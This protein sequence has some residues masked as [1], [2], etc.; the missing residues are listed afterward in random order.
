MR[1]REILSIL[2]VLSFGTQRVHAERGASLMPDSWFE[3]IPGTMLSGIVATNKQ[4]LV[5][6]KPI[7]PHP[8]V[9]RKVG[10][11]RYEPVQLLGLKL[12]QGASS[13]EKYCWD[14][15]IS[16]GLDCSKL[17]PTTRPSSLGAPAT[18]DEDL[19]LNARKISKTQ[20]MRRAREYLEEAMQRTDST[21]G[22]FERDVIRATRDKTW[23]APGSVLR[24]SKVERSR[25][26]IFVIFGIDLSGDSPNRE[27]IRRAAKEL[28]HMGFAA[29]LVNTKP[30]VSY[31]ANARLIGAEFEEMVDKVDHVIF[32]AASKGVADLLTYMLHDGSRASAQSRAKVRGIV[33]LSGVVRGSNMAQWLTHSE[34]KRLD[35]VRAFIARRPTQPMEGIESLALDPWQGVPR[36]QLREDFPHLKWISV[37]MLPAGNDGL[38]PGNG[39]MLEL[40]Q[41]LIRHGQ[42]FSPSDGLVESAATILPPGTGIPQRIVRGYGPHALALGH[43]LNGDALAPQNLTEKGVDPAA[44]AEILS[45][46]MR[47]LGAE[48]L[49]NR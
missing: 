26:G 42:D 49:E 15:F 37:S 32:V 2:F 30:A 47:A 22:Q 25:I 39:V 17:L 43:F 35:V 48:L 38:V 12:R 1:T 34:L 29:R 19:L 7:G 33:S 20:G 46:F 9:F 24:L 41:A 6:K 36:A 18:A 8:K 40:Q 4:A 16:G 28:E 21:Q 5:Y 23:M 3:K 27:L 44:G 31:E 13:Q 14:V 45:S 10:L 11:S